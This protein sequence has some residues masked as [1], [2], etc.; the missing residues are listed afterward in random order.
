MIKTFFSLQ[1]KQWVTETVTN[2]KHPFFL[3][4]NY[5]WSVVIIFLLSA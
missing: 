4:H 3:E 5:R 1:Q 2:R